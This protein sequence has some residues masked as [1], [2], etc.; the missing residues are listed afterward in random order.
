MTPN[1]ITA[2][3]ERMWQEAIFASPIILDRKGETVVHM[4]KSEFNAALLQ[5]EAVVR[6]EIAKELA[7]AGTNLISL[8]WNHKDFTGTYWVSANDAYF[9]LTGRHMNTDRHEGKLPTNTMF[10][11]LLAAADTQ[12]RTTKPTL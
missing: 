6:E 5:H 3:R 4:S 10:D 7:M 1:P 12:S 11:D 8:F 2:S 9:S